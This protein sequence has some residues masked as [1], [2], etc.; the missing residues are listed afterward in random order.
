MC[1]D[2]QSK[3]KEMIQWRK[4]QNNDRIE[5]NVTGWNIYAP[6]HPIEKIK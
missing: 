6:E 2:K 4:K 5:S 3:T 1:K